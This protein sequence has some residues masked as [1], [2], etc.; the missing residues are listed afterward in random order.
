MGILSH[1]IGSFG[2]LSS[3]LL[4]SFGAVTLFFPRITLYALVIYFA[5]SV[6]FGGIF[7]IVQSFRT[8]KATANKY[9]MTTEG[10]LG[11]LIGLFLIIKPE[12]SAAVF[13]AII[14][15]W[16]LVMGGLYISFLFY[17]RKSKQGSNMGLL[18]VNAVISLIFGAVLLFNPFESTQIILI[19]LAIYAISYGIFAMIHKIRHRN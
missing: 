5:V 3:L 11:I 16:A 10:V 7:L 4:I 6:I 9:L 2:I 18:F 1:R 19:V 15:I 8:P 13:V 12:L 17:L 14:G